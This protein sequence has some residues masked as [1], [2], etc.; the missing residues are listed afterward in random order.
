MGYLF[1]ELK[2]LV[3]NPNSVYNYVLK[4][5]DT[6]FVPK[7]ND[8]V[9]ICGA[10]EYPDI[11]SILQINAPY[12]KRKRAK[13][14]VKKFGVDFDDQKR[15]KRGKTTV[16]LPNGIVTKTKNYGL[17]KIYPKVYKGSKVTVNVKKKKED[18]KEKIEQVPVDWNRL[19]ENLTVK[20]SGV[21]TLYFLISRI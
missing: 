18:I 20:V 9:S 17:F 19:F 15:A 1:I 2:K 11:D 12:I 13:Y 14:Y 16:T 10:I 7:V 21:L 3:N 8:L 4:P 5:G 6:I